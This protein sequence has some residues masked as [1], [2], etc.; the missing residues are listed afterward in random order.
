MYLE[1]FLILSK[2]LL[3]TVLYKYINMV[4]REAPSVAGMRVWSEYPGDSIPGTARVPIA[5]LKEVLKE[6]ETSLALDLG[7]GS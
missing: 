5:E 2:V 4:T 1:S 7:S 3:F 6:T